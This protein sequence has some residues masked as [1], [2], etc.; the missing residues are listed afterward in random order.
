MFSFVEALHLLFPALSFLSFASAILFKRKNF[1]AASLWFGLFGLFCHYHASG[2]E[3][4]G[5]YFNY[6]HALFYSINLIFVVLSVIIILLNWKKKLNNGL[7]LGTNL[8]SFCL[9]IT[10]SFLLA[11]I[12]TNAFFVEKKLAGTPIL[13]VAMFT[14]KNY[15]EYKYIFYKLHQ[16][17]RISYLCPNHYGLLP[18]VGYLKRPPTLVVGQLPHELKRNLSK[19]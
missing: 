17:K 7:K 13:Q 2:G 19:A 6:Q 18:S 9:V 10:C 11:N 4:L 8:L 14:K 1:Y 12:W 5:N 3:I 15:C 16:D